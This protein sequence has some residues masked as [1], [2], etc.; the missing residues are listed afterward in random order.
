MITDSSLEPLGLFHFQSLL[1]QSKITKCYPIQ[2]HQAWLARQHNILQERMKKRF[3]ILK[4]STHLYIKFQMQEHTRQKYIVAVAKR[5]VLGHWAPH[6][7]S[8]NRSTSS[9]TGWREIWPPFVSAL[10]TAGWT[11]SKDG[12]HPAQGT[13]FLLHPCAGASPS[14]VPLP[15]PG[16][17]HRPA[18]HL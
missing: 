6:R 17:R 12:A 4:F 18:L 10:W 14:E 16:F 8:D 2:L 1:I 15:G 13:P 9:C 3:W 5:H 11:T 7:H